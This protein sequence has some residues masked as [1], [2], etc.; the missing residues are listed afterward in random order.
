MQTHNYGEDPYSVEASQL[1]NRRKLAELLMA[2]SLSPSPVYSNKAGIAKMLT[3]LLGGLERGAAEKGERDLAERKSRA[4]KEE[5]EGILAAAQSPEGTPGRAQLA[6]LL[7]RSSN[8]DRQK[9]GLGVL[10]ARPEKPEE[11]TLPEGGK[12]YRGP[13]LI[14]ENPKVEKPEKEPE[15]VRAIRAQ[16]EA[17]GIDPNSDIGKGLFRKALE[18]ATSHQQPTQVTVN[19]GK[20]FGETLATEV[21]QQVAQSADAARGAVDTLNTA[22]QIETAL[23]SGKVMAGP[24]T[25]GIMFIQQ[26]I[27][28]PSTEEG[29]VQTRQVIQGLARMTLAARKQLK[30]QGQVSDFEGKLLAKAESGDIDALTIPEIQ[31]I[32]KTATRVANGSIVQHQSYL[33]KIESDPELKGLAPFFNIQ[34]PGAGGG[35]PAIDELLNLYGPKK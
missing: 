25:T 14:A 1:A 31:A 33:K 15:S 20:K 9:A 34:T 13:Q 8:P 27:N 35:N 19:T 4:S 10:L 7:A 23:A 22:K 21:A 3:G 26:A 5:M 18:K 28:A 24:G 29:R 32:V 6:E 16:M 11:Y 17:A 12:R 2:Q 30:G